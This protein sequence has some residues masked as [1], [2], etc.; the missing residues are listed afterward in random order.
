MKKKRSN[1]S[2]GALYAVNNATNIRPISQL[3]GIV[4]LKQSLGEMEGKGIC[5]VVK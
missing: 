4:Q 5:S 3:D 2:V 1:E